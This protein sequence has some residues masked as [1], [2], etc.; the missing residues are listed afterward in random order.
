MLILGEDVTN[1]APMLDYSLRQW[2]RR[3][4]NLEQDRSL[5]IPD[6][7]DAAVGE[8]VHEEPSAL[9]VAQR[10]ARPSS[11]ASPARST[12]PPPPIWPGLGFAVAHLLD[13]AR[14]PTC[15][16]CPPSMAE[17]A[18]EITAAFARG[19]SGRSSSRAS[20][21]A[22]RTIMQAA[23]KWPGPCAPGARSPSSPSWCPSATAWGWASWGAGR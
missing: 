16:T 8:I 4:P 10:V 11:T 5:K 13:D 6:W 21:A 15:P 7:N 9:H 1:T 20:A 2:L 14:S 23:A 19:R 3:R 17:H 12:M 22:A 18:A